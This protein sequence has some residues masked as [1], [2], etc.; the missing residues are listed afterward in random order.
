MASAPMTN[1]AMRPT[2]LLPSLF[3]PEILLGCVE[4]GSV[5][6]LVVSFTIVVAKEKGGLTTTDGADIDAVAD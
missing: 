4:S 6:A 3:P 5:S 1:P 2:L